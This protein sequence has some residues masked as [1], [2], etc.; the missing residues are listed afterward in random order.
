MIA[1]IKI[2]AETNYPKEIIESL[3]IDNV[4]VPDGMKISMNYDEKQIYIE[5]SMEIKSARSMLTLRNTADEILEQIKMLEG[6]LQKN[7]R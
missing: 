6:L 4:D 7:D 5:I 3:K 2:V 1:K